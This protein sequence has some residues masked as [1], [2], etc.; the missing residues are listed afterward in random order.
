MTHLWAFFLAFT[1]AL[2][3]IAFTYFYTQIT[4]D[5]RRIS[6]NLREYGGFV[7]GQRPGQQ[8]QEYLTRI[9]NRITLWGALFLGAVNAIP[10]ILGWLT[11]QSEQAGW[12][13]SFV[14]SDLV[15]P[16]LYL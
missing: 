6:D 7:P 5:P 13:S 8:T 1:F 16:R 12:L 11:L 3:V 15:T 9:T 4:F 14:S 10:T 2:M